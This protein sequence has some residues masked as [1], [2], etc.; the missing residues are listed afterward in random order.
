MNN[1]ILSRDYFTLFAIIISFLCEY[2]ISLPHDTQYIRGVG[3]VRTAL[4]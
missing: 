2:A 3:R 4:Y 1:V